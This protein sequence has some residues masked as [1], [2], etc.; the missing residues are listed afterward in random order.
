MSGKE[1]G[2]KKRNK[3]ERHPAAPNTPCSAWMGLLHSLGYFCGVGPHTDPKSF[4]LPALLL[5]PVCSSGTVWSTKDGANH[6]M[7]P[8]CWGT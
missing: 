8:E 5:C 2:L 1:Y 6:T 3:A 7:S 4:Q